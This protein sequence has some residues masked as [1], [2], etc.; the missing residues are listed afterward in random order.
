[1]QI[2][3]ET[4]KQLAGVNMTFVPFAGGNAP[5]VNA[6]LGNHVNAAL[7]NYAEVADQLEGKLRALAT[8]SPKR[9][10]PLPDVP[11]VNELGSGDSEADV[12]FGV[13]VPGR[14]PS[15]IV[16]ELIDWFKAAMEAPAV[17][18]KLAAMWLY[19]VGKCGADFAADLRHRL[20]DYGRVIRETNIKA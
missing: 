5:A 20:D 1:Q 11:A 10:D 3:F 18:P 7:V 12:W 9:L 15:A 19:P 16:A 2:A 4:L 17:K 8:T 14:T 6:L 13:V